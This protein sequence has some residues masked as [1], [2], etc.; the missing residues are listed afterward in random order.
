[1]DDMNQVKYMI[2]VTLPYKFSLPSLFTDTLNTCTSYNPQ[3][4]LTSSLGYCQCSKSQLGGYSA[5]A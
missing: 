2:P 1:M 5:T 4:S 3:S